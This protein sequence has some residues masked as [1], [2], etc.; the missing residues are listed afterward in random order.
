MYEIFLNSN[1]YLMFLV[2]NLEYIVETLPLEIESKYS[3]SSREILE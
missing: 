3:Q 2:D 1:N